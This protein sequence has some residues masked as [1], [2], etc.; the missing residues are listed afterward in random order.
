MLFFV[1]E[2]LLRFAAVG[3]K[4]FFC[5][6]D[7]SWNC[8]DF[9]VIAVSVADVVLDYV[10]QLTPSSVN[11]QQLRLVRSVRLAR[12]LRGVRI[13]WLFERL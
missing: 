3:F 11:T 9:A 4:P 6:E 10:S 1:L 12:A 8:F 7:S 2:L 5:G 13:V